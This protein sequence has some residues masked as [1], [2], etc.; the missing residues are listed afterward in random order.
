MKKNSVSK[1][2]GI[3]APW[4]I[5]EDAYDDTA[6][7]RTVTV[8]C[9]DTSS[10][11][12]PKCG[13]ASPFYDLRSARQWRHLDTCKYQTALRAQVP[14]VKCS[15]CGVKTA[16][17]PWAGPSSRYTYDF[18][19]SV[20]GWIKEAS[21]L[22]ISRQ[23][24]LGWKAIAGI[25]HRAVQRGLARKKEQ[26]VANI[27]VDEV[28]YKKGHKY[29]TVVSDADTATVLYVGIGRDQKV[30]MRWFQQLSTEQLNGI[31]SMSMDMWPAYISATLACLPDAKKKICFDRF[32]VAKHLGVSVDKVQ[33]KALLKEGNP[34]L[35]GTK[36][37][38]LK[39]PHNMSLAQKRA[40]HAIRTS[41]IKTSKAWA[42][43]ETFRKMW[44][45][46]SATWALKGWNKTLSWAM[47]CRLEPVKDVAR[48]IRKHLW[49]IIN[50]IVLDVSNGPAE[51]I[52]SRIKTVKIRAHGF[53]NKERFVDAIYF[54][55]GGLDLSPRYA[56]S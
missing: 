41:S 54:Q 44:D 11:E 24:G 31:R 19:E 14:R 10:L 51:S 23:M 56:K 35:T 43:K 2:L 18:E 1:S 22:A 6:K 38:W 5:L 20:I 48:M 37:S 29:F 55:L 26:V 42:I 28:A 32:H 13:K 15:E 40:F 27:C 45:Y 12:C 49:G 47:R 17:V 8:T 39:S 52:N 30:L 46:K 3:E 53:R 21:I 25:V 4:K 9:T 33:H 36:Y 50:A 7:Q 34:I 16:R